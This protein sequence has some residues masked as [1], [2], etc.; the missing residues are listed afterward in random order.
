[1]THSDGR[2]FGMGKR[3]Y[4][5]MLDTRSFREWVAER[6]QNA[7][8]DDDDKGAMSFIC[9]QL[10]GGTTLKAISDHYLVEFGLLYDFAYQTP[11]RVE[12]IARAERGQ[13]EFYAGENIEIADAL[14]ENGEV[15]Y[16]RDVKRDAL[17][18]KV[19]SDQMKATNREKYGGDEA[20]LGA[21]L[22]NLAS[23][24]KQIS[25]RKQKQLAAPAQEITDVQFTEPV[26]A[27]SDYL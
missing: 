9:A 1:M 20:K 27:E 25:E 8:T 12:R 21:D 26:L 3:S 4:V 6:N 5:K 11:E 18:I 15:D 24:L 19:R 17:R 10:V 7:Q 2:P 22:N 14:D 16:S 13:A 23:V